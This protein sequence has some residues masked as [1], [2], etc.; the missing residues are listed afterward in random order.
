[1]VAT[2]VA[3]LIVPL[4][5]TR[6]SPGRLATAIFLLAL[7]GSLA[8]AYLPETVVER[9]GTARSEMEGGGIGGRLKLWKAGLKAFIREPIVGYGPGGYIKAIYP[10][11]GWRSQ[12][13]H[14]SYLS[15]L[16]EEGAVGFL[17]YMAMLLLV[18]RAILRLPPLERR[19]ALV[20]L[21]TVGVAM[22]P[23]TWEDRKSVWIIL[24]ALLGFARAPDAGTGEAVQ[25]SQR[26][27]PAAP[28]AP[29][30]APR[31]GVPVATRA[32][33]ANRGIAR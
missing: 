14:N 18:L 28:A 2:I 26:G 6:L 1:M 22:L 12:V 20:L 15:V 11:L 25:V 16:V 24:A 27:W 9:L 5:M 13:A 32:R 4:A 17:L 23:L 3:L 33:G 19:F 31:A 30:V 21:A 7:S 10:Q 29:G 8:V